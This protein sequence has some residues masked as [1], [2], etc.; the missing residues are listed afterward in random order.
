MSAATK[1]KAEGDFEGWW[2]NPL[3]CVDLSKDKA[4]GK[5][6]LLKGVAKCSVVEVSN[7]E[8]AGCGGVL[9]LGGGEI[10]ALFARPLQ[11][12]DVAATDLSAIKMAL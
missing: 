9:S 4:Y 3:E 1:I 6:H 5:A 10:R 12:S 7:A 8:G 11:R 2:N